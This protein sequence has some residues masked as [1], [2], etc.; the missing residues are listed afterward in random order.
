MKTPNLETWNF[1]MVY[2]MESGLYSVAEVYYDKKDNPVGWCA[3]DLEHYENPKELLIA[4]SQ[5]R[6]DVEGSSC[7]EY[8]NAADK[9][10]ERT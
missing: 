8:D 10:K 7:L 2:E 9:F 4:M 6:R 3:A 1:R 5:M